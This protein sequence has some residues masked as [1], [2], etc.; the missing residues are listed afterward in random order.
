M[1]PMDLIAI[2]ILPSSS[3]FHSEQ[4][5]FPGLVGARALEGGV[6]TRA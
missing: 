3:R 2:L 4:L 6:E 5:T 1:M